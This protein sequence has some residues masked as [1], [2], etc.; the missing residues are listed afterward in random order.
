MWREA[1][2]LLQ[3]GGVDLE[4]ESAEATLTAPALTVC[5]EMEKLSLNDD[6]EAPATPRQTS[7]TTKADIDITHLSAP[8]LD[9]TRVPA[10]RGVHVSGVPGLRLLYDVVNAQ[11]EEAIM[12]SLLADRSAVAANN[13]HRATQWGWVFYSSGQRMT[14]AD[15]L[16]PLPRWMGALVDRTLASD[17][18]RQFLPSLE[19]WGDGVQHALLNEYEPGDGVRAHT[20]DTRFWREFVLGLSLGSAV[21]MRF[22]SPPALPAGSVS[23]LIAVQTEAVD[24]RLPARSLY[25]LTG[26]SRWEWKHEIAYQLEDIVADISVPRGH[27]MSVTLRGIDARWMPDDE[28]QREPPARVKN[29]ESDEESL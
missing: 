22:T 6:D 25:V 12:S 15:R 17:P 4:S 23:S 2:R 29:D 8:I 27:R 28:L 20:D 10:L 7:S 18:T 13:I 5:A 24:V 1:V 9:P 16:S 14:H 26:A 3:G 11:E 19:D 21:T